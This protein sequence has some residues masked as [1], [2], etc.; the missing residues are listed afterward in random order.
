MSARDRELGIGQ[1]SA[2]AKLTVTRQ[3]TIHQRYHR[4]SK[5]ERKNNMI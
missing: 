2:G 4:L 3:P 1:L 5:Y